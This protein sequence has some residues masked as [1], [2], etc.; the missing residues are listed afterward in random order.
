MRQRKVKNVGERLA[1]FAE[2]SVADGKKMKGSWKGLFHNE[3]D[4]YV[5]LGCG[6]GQFSIKQAEIHPDRNYIAV[7][8][9]DTVILRALEKAAAVQLPNIKFLKAFIRDV[10]EY[11]D[12]DELAGIYL[13][14]SDPWPKERHAKRRLTHTRFLKEYE[15]VIRNSGIV[16]FKTDNDALFEFSIG[17][18]KANGFEILEYSRDLHNSAFPS[19]EVTTEY[20][21]KFT[22]FNKCINYVKFVV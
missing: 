11:F 2:Y 18:I 15:K 9:Q 7:E 21:D 6:K 19:K 12:E 5:E 3:N 17:E 16:E 22:G 13:N 10:T 4:I 8:G 20:E 14:F 1:T